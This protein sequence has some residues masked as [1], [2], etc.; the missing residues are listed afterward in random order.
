MRFRSLMRIATNKI[1]RKMT[2]F[3]FN[4]LNPTEMKMHLPNENIDVTPTLVHDLVRIPLGGKDVYNN[5][6]CEGTS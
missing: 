6:Q 3:I 2:H 5:N 4:S 1:S